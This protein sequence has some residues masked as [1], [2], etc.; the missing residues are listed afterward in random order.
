ML[1]YCGINCQ[2][3][4]AYKG[5]SDYQ[6]SELEQ[7]AESLSDGKYSA[8]DWACLGCQPADQPFL[9]KY[10]AE[11]KIRFCAI[12][13]KLSNCAACHDFESCQLLHRFIQDESAELV[14]KMQLLRNRFLDRQTNSF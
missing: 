14:A 11:C 7:L 5:T 2:E 6:S 3:C 13:R 8:K 4:R 10:C 9:A 1:G 12:Q